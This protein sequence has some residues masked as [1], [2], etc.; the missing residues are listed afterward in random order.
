MMGG[1]QVVLNSEAETHLS[2]L[3]PLVKN[4]DFSGSRLSAASKSAKNLAL[5]SVLVIWM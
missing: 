1:W 5:T 2:A 4:H 3:Y